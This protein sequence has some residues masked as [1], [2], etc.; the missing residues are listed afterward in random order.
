MNSL[1]L[2]GPPE[3]V[4]MILQSCQSL[5]DLARLSATSKRIYAIWRAH[6]SSIIWHVGLRSILS[7]DVALMTVSS[8]SPG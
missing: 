3:L 7:F 6:H 4:V 2:E 8:Y 5:G 1:L